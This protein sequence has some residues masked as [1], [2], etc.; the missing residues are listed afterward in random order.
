M[1]LKEIK[2]DWNQWNIQKNEIKHGVSTLEAESVFFDPLLKI[3]ED[4]IHSTPKEK[5]WIS[6]GKSKLNRV[7]M[8]SFTL[9]G[10]KIRIISAR[11]SSKKER[12]VYDEN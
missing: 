11:Q 1:F 6:Y 5:R 10:E 3:Y 9:R 4:I 12:Q 8:I 2:F 7:L